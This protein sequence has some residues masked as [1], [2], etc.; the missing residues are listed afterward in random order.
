MAVDTE[1]DALLVDGRN[2]LRTAPHLVN[3]PGLAIFVTVLGFN[4]IGNTLRDVFDPR[5][6]V[7]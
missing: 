7:R 6:R 5:L 1:S 2:Y 4:L 3:V